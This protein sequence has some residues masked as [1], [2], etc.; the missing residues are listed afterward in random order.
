MAFNQYQY[1]EAAF[2]KLPF[3]GELIGYLHTNSKGDFKKG[4]LFKISEE[5]YLKISKRLEGDDKSSIMP[6]DKVFILP[7]CSIPL[8]K[9]KEYLKEIGRAHV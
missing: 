8:F 2:Q 3:L 4:A 9:M 6:K 5:D 7:N 1:D